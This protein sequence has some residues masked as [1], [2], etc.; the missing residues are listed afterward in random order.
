VLIVDRKSEAFG[1][2][3]ISGWLERQKQVV[4]DSSTYSWASHLEWFRERHAEAMVWLMRKAGRAFQMISRFEAS[5]AYLHYTGTRAKSLSYLMGVGY[6]ALKAEKVR[7]DA[8]RHLLLRC[9]H[10][11]RAAN[12]RDEAR[13]F[14]LHTAKEVVATAARLAAGIAIN[15]LPKKKQPANYNIVYKLSYARTEAISF[16]REKARKGV[17]L[18]GRQTE[19]VRWLLDLRDRVLGQLRPHWDASD[20]LIAYALKAHAHTVAQDSIWVRLIGAGHRAVE[21]TAGWDAALWWLMERG[22]KVLAADARTHAAYSYLAA[23]GSNAVVRVAARSTAASRLHQRR[24]N[25]VKLLQAKE[26]SFAYLRRL[27][28]AYWDNTERYAEAAQWL[29]NRSMR[30]YEHIKRQHAASKRLQVRNVLS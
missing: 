7:V 1:P 15:L 19:A 4:G 20:W 11:R 29:L 10:A 5:A 17:V 3:H 14:L 25:A 22:D 30:G 23:A 24:D 26:E 9:T 6:A 16:L 27:P 13:R 28:Q 2:L 18:H 8:K 12:R 21:K